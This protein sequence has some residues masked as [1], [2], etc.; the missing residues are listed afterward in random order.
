MPLEP[1]SSQEAVSKN[2]ET[3]MHHGKPQKQA[4]AIAMKEAGMSKSKD[5]GPGTPSDPEY[6]RQ[7]K[8]VGGGKSGGPGT[9]SDPEYSRQ[10]K[11]VGGG[12][13]VNT[14]S[15]GTGPMATKGPPGKSEG[16]PKTT[17]AFDRAA[18]LGK[19][20]DMKSIKDCS[21]GFP[22]GRK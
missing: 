15:P 17:E 4:I 9:S 5:G 18:P 21:S 10:P 6:S 1:G 19:A 3:E 12:K 2:I 8:S 11:S 16:L 7:P 22:M 13:D 14:I 20:M